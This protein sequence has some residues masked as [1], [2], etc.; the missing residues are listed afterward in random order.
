MKTV[1]L[2]VAGL[3]VAALSAGCV[4]ARQ[5]D[6]AFNGFVYRSAVADRDA[7]N[8]LEGGGAPTLAVPLGK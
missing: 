5:G 2:L 4:Y 8:L 3:L 1:F 6:V 7:D